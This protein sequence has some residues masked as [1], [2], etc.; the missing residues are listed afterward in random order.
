MEIKEEKKNQPERGKTNI[1]ENIK[2]K[3]YYKKC[4]TFEP[5]DFSSLFRI[6][7]HK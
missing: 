7:H 5:I 1:N 6:I 2:K 3:E 4:I